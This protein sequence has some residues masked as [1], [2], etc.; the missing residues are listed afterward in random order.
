MTE[1]PFEI[2]GPNMTLIA[3]RA[4]ERAVAAVSEQAL[5]DCNYYCKQNMGAL[6]ESSL[7]HSDI[8]KGV[9]KWVTPYAE[10]QYYLPSVCKDKNPNASPRWCEKAEENH[11]DEWE[12][13]FI[14][15]LHREGL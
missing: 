3:D 9:L 13:K 15:T 5:K 12:I 14:D 4:M 11:A 8:G 1:T 7:I 6:I 2:R 10:K